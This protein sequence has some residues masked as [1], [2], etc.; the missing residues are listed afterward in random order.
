MNRRIV[1]QTED[2]L[3]TMFHLV[4][5]YSLDTESW[6]TTLARPGLCYSAANIT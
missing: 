4:R 2:N 3:I 5:G 6:G 1:Q